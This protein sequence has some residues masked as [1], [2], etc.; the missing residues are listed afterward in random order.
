MHDETCFCDEAK[1]GDILSP[2]HLKSG[3]EEKTEVWL[4]FKILQPSPVTSCILQ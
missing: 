3:I 4:A 2:L 1:A